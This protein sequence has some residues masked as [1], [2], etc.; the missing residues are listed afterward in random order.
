MPLNISDQHCQE[1]TSQKFS[2]SWF[3]GNSQFMVKEEY[4]RYH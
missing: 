4:A 3:Y 1:M 2:V